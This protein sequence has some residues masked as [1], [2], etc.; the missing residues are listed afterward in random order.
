MAVKPLES[1]FLRASLS[2]DGANSTR[3]LIEERERERGNATVNLNNQPFLDANRITEILVPT[4]QLKSPTSGSQ[5]S[6]FVQ[7][8]VR[9]LKISSKSH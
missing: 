1:Q 2:K 7:A 6:S 9:T 5:P 8:S 4:A 3:N